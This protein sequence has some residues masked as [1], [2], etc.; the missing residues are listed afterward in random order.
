M[1][2]I[3]L[4]TTETDK[5][6]SI[7]INKLIESRGVIQGTS[8]SGK[9]GL[10]RVICE[11]VSKHIPFIL[12]DREGE[13]ATLREKVD[14][15]L[16]GANG[17]VPTDVRSADLL[18][19]KLVE[20]RVSAVID[21]Y[22]LKIPQQREYVRRFCEALISL[23]KDLYHPLL[24][25][26]D[27]AHLF[28]PERGQRGRDIVSTEAVLDLIAQGRKR[29]FSTLL[30][31]QRFSKV[32]NDALAELKNVF[33]G[34]TWLDADQKTAG[35]Y[36]GLT[37]ND[38]R[39]L[40]DVP[41]RTFHCFGPALSIHGVS[42]M[43]VDT[44]ESKFPKPGETQT[45]RLPKASDAIGHILEQ[46]DDLPE[47]AE[48]EKR[49][50]TS[51]TVENQELKKK[52]ADRPTIPEPVTEYVD[53]EVPVMTPETIKA[54]TDLTDA[55]SQKVV[56]LVDD[57][58]VHLADFEQVRAEI[59]AAVERVTG[60]KT[61]Q[62][63]IPAQPA[64]S[65]PNKPPAQIISRPAVRPATEIRAQDG[66]LSPLQQTILN[67][68][69]LLH[70]IGY[71]SPSIQQVCVVI[72]KGANAGP[73]RGAFN[74]LHDLGYA[75]LDGNAV[76]LTDVGQ[77]LAVMPSITSRADIHNLWYQ[78]L[79]GNE[80]EFLR[81]L[82]SAYPHTLSY[83]ELGKRIGKNINAGPIRGALN[84]LSE[85]GLVVLDSDGAQASDV[86]FPE[87]LG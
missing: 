80:Q 45:L 44:A 28:V 61:V 1:T 29:G 25:V 42:K 23:P 26:I 79:Q 18:A 78:R 21:L 84:A 38:R 33:I 64:P 68:I 20:L 32:H 71:H 43:Y 27:E 87:G 76:S 57:L 7:D 36:L 66:E 2:K 34:S 17:D 6:L 56:T 13:F 82:I 52:L 5:Q 46:L 48:Q 4:G 49:D 24:V 73:V 55:I 70:K 50:I 41:K 30:A 15:V 19:R 9:S 59:V 72:G 60:E 69:A 22:D 39:Q 8:G 65:P 77:V 81:I 62:Q 10:I 54:A 47:I 63:S 31:T 83:A 35:E 58:N 67:G 75:S 37:G 3:P 74:K 14:L 51:L 85:K 53:K 40:R 12:L 11:R 16:V 86:F